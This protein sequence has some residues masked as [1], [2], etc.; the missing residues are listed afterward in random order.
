VAAHRMRAVL[1][2]PEPVLTAYDQDAWAKNLDYQRR[3]PK[4][5]LETFRRLRAE[6]HELLKGLPESAFERKGNHTENGP[7]SLL[8]IVEGYVGHVE[9][10]AQQM[11]EIREHYKKH[12]GK[13]QG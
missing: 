8:Q 6:N 11:Q 2:E 13:T 5:S 10:H 3:K 12:K 9:S 4:Q 7:V 1:A